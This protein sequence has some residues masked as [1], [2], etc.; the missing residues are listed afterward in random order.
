LMLGSISAARSIEAEISVWLVLFNSNVRSATEGQTAGGKASAK[1]PPRD[2]CKDAG[3]DARYSPP[4]AENVLS[5]H[6]F[7]LRWKRL[8]N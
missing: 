3:C 8:K 2:Q 7:N 5:K 1:P 6:G 4:R